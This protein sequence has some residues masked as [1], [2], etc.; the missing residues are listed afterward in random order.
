MKIPLDSPVGQCKIVL[1]ELLLNS[2]DI[3]LTTKNCICYIDD[4]IKDYLLEKKHDD[5]LSQDVSF[6][7]QVGGV[8]ESALCSFSNEA[9]IFNN[10]YLGRYKIETSY[11]PM[12][13]RSFKA[14]SI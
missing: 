12:S 8:S 7:A 9:R 14:V 5:W 2:P 1:E 11:G 4:L 13:V 6:G 10:P 3:P